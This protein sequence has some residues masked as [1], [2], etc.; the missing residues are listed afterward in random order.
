MS[1]QAMAWAIKQKTPS[2]AS[3]L[4][5][6]VLA[7]YADDEN[8]C[9]PSHDH[10]S[11]IS[12]CTRRSVITY[13]KQLEKNGFI[14]VVRT[15]DGMKKINRYILRC[16]KSSHNTNIKLSENISQRKP[17]EI[18]KKKTRNKNFLAM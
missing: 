2:T 7:N 9:Y 6:L 14:N 3:K 16:E 1:F 15:K 8:S 13:I 12:H 10:I 18:F 4:V 17:K 5:L 11:T